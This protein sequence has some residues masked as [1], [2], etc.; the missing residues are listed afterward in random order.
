MCMRIV[1]EDHSDGRRSRG[2][3]LCENQLTP[4]QLS[5][6]VTD[7]DSVS[8]EILEHLSDCDVCAHRVAIARHFGI[9]SVSIERRRF[10]G[11]SWLGGALRTAAMLAIIFG[12][13]AIVLSMHG[14]RLFTAGDFVLGDGPIGPQPQA[15]AAA[16][17][18]SELPTR[19]DIPGRNDIIEPQNPTD[20]IG[21]RKDSQHR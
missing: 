5:M 17:V 20:F 14:P 7:I 19:P 10:R 8:P 1:G 2:S 16:I 21:Q 4:R 13:V 12:G 3:D 11:V 18:R 15:P 6:A 9:S